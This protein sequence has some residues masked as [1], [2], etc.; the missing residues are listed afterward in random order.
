MLATL[1]ST[2]TGLILEDAQYQQLSDTFQHSIDGNM[3]LVKLTD[4]SSAELYTTRH[5]PDVNRSSM[6]YDCVFYDTIKM[7]RTITSSIGS[8]LIIAFA[9]ILASISVIVIK[10]R[11]G[12]SIEEDMHNIGA[13]K[14]IGYTGKDIVNSFLLQFL[15][16]TII[17]AIFGIAC[18][19]HFCPCSLIC[20]R[21]KQELY[22]NQDLISY[23]HY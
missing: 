20:L 13:L 3:Y 6:L 12:N 10:F 1:N 11:I 16:M 22:G 2:T 9:V 5:T 17:G 19:M 4:P 18:H 15:T 8:L 21:F 23:Q 14:A 7:A